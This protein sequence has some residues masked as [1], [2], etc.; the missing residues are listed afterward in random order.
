MT[1]GILII[2]QKEFETWCRSERRKGKWPS[3]WSRSK[4]PAGRP[5]KR[6]DEGLRDAVLA[7]VEDGRWNGGMGIPSLHQALGS[8]GWKISEDTLS[9]MV[10][11]LFD[12]TSDSRLRRT[13]RRVKR[14]K[15]AKSRLLPQN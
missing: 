2:D 15:A 14:P 3:Q 9:R 11:D 10:D 8:N 1:I 6:T 13:K 7:R 5:S 4:R 12:D